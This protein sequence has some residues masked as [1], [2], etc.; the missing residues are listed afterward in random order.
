MIQ[1]LHITDMHVYADPEATLKGIRTRQSLAGV[2]KEVRQHFP[3]PDLIILGGDL[4]QDGSSAAYACIAEMFDSFPTLAVAGNHDAPARLQAYFAHRT[5]DMG[6]WRIVPLHTHHAGHESGLLGKK[7]LTELAAG[8]EE[9]AGRHVLIVL[10]H[11]PVPVGS[12]W[13]DAI[14]L[15]DA[16]AFWA[17]VARFPHVR[18]VLCGHIHQQ[19]DSKHRGVRVLGTPASCIQF[20]PQR[21]TFEL[22]NQSPGYRWLQLMPDGDIV[23][24]VERISGFIPSDLADNAPY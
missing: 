12:R 3:Q 7:Q 1:L 13:L 22:D 10:H 18:G 4:A 9:A 23:S 2:L 20:Q 8:L 6:N 19:L 14:G 17:V 24:G 11:P 21:Q 15:A 5:V 16:E